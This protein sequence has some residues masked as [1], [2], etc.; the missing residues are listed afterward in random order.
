M[1]FFL[2]V[3]HD[4]LDAVLVEISGHLRQGKARLG[5]LE[6]GPVKQ[7][8]VVSLKLNL[9]ALPEHPA[10]TPQEALVGEAAAGMLHRRPGIA[11]VDVDEVHLAGGEILL[12]GGGVSVNKEHVGKAQG[13]A[14]FHCDDHGVR[15]PLHSHVKIRRVGGG[16]FGGET[17]LAAAQFQPQEGCI[18]L[19]RTPTPLFCCGVLHQKRSAGIHP[20]RQV[21]LFPHPHSCSPHLFSRIS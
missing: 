2:I 6:Q 16:S 9:P 4:P 11:K 8:A 14:A 17:A 13:P 12:Q 19:V 21:F 20:G 18:R 5:E 1:E 15:H 7:G 3:G 10:V